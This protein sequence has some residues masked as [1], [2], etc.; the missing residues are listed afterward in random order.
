MKP[1][2]EKATNGF[3]NFFRRGQFERDYRSL[4]L[5]LELLRMSDLCSILR[6]GASHIT[7]LIKA[8]NHSFVEAA[9]AVTGLP[10]LHRSDAT[11]RLGYVEALAGSSLR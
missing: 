8:N 3:W 2:C 9:V 1:R 6:S 5:R 4:G 11:C 7:M 10:C